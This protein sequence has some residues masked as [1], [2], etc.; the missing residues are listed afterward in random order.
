MTR[1]SDLDVRFETVFRKQ[2]P[3]YAGP[4]KP[5]LTA[6]DVDGWDSLSHANLIM[7]MED[8]FGVEIDPAKAF[9]FATLGELRNAVAPDDQ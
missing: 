1:P 5:A 7:A 4:V 3:R 6:A 2:F 8:E 9:E